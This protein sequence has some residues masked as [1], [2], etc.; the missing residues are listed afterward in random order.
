[1]NKVSGIV[2]VVAALVVVVAIGVGIGLLSSKRPSHS[3]AVSQ[4]TSQEGSAS[5]Q[6][7]TMPAVMSKRPSTNAVG[8]TP[9][10]ALAQASQ[11]EQ[12]IPAPAPSNVMTNWEPKLEEILDSNVA[13]K[14]KATQMAAMLPNLPEEGQT[15]VAGHLSNLVMDEDYGLI[16]GFMTNAALSEPVLDIF[17]A[18]S[19]NR[20]NA[21]KLPLLLDVARNPQ[22]PKAG[23]AKDILQLFLD[24]DYGTDWT[25]WGTKLQEWMK[26]NP[27]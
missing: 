13:E 1:M 23:E 22:H 10:A 19:L 17:L 6:P 4:A 16:A 24:E 9:P 26:A 25:L 20:P 3:P 21:I 5:S 27:D 2:K 15:E 11:D 8:G 14:E 7:T 18:D 12:G